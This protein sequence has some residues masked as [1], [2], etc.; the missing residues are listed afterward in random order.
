M[1]NLEIVMCILMLLCVSSAVSPAPQRLGMP[2][3]RG[4]RKSE[5]LVRQVSG[6]RAF[7]NWPLWDS[8]ATSHSYCLPKVLPKKSFMFQVGRCVA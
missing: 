2:D 7:E 6:Y 5:V 8:S 3:K 4:N 1:K